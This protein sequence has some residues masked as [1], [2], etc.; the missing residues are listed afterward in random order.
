VSDSFLSGG[1]PL[2]DP[3]VR[4]EPT[5]QSHVAQAHVLIKSVKQRFDTVLRVAKFIVEHQQ[6]FFDQGEQAMRPL[7]LRD[8]AQDL[9]LHESTISRAT[10]QKYAQTPWG[11]IELKRFFGTALATDDGSDTS[12]M[13]VRSLII[14][15]IREESVSKPL[16]DSK[17]AEKLARNGVVIARRTVAKYREAV[18]IE[19]ASVRKARA[20]LQQE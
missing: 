14:K 1:N 5:L 18:G 7:L 16:S 10:R 3:D 2:A 17:I 15:L 8:I 19:A 6:A 13:A 11:V 20:S 4:N 9:E 12:A